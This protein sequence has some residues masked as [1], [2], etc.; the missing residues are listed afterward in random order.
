MTKR[1]FVSHS[2]ED[3]AWCEAFVDELSKYDV[4]VWLDR[5]G[6]HAGDQWM[7]RIEDELA[8]R[9]TLWL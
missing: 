7:Q 6:L 5:K 2:H 4:D 1:I 8:S 9:N 3:N